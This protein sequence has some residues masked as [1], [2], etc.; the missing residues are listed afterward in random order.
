MLR[1]VG[2][3]AGQH[4]ILA[5]NFAK[6]NYKKITESAT[7]LKERRKR[8]MREA[9]K[10]ASDLKKRFKEM[11]RSKEKFRKSFEEQEK[12]MLTFKRA[13]ND[14]S[15]AR[16]EVEKL[17]LAYNS[18]TQHCETVKG[19]Y[20]SQLIK[21]NDFQRE[22]YSKLFPKVLD[23]LQELEKSRIGIM[24]DSI[25]ACV[26]K[27]KEVN[28]IINKCHDSMIQAMDDI[29]PQEDTE[30]VIER[31]KSGDVP[32]RDFNFD[33]MSSPLEMLIKEPV[34]KK[35]N[36]NLYPR[37][38]ELERMIDTIEKELAQRVKELSSF[39]TLVTTYEANP[40]FGSKDD[41]KK[42][43]QEI[44]IHRQKIHEMETE[45]ERLNRE[46]S[47]VEDRLESLKNNSNSLS[48]SPMLL[49]RYHTP[50]SS[51]SSG[52]LKS[53]SLSIGST[54]A[55]S[56]MNTS[57]DHSVPEIVYDRPN[58]EWGE[59]EEEEEFPPPPPESTT[60][61][62]PQCYA[63]YAYDGSSTDESSNIIPMGEGERFYVVEEDYAGW[64]RVR[65]IDN[66]Y[67]NDEGEGFVPSSFIQLL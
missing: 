65:R 21:T 15:V 17:R 25:K 6:E 32:P 40:K 43:Q 26:Y 27:E 59:E 62:L 54:Q 56:T 24:R 41:L 7:R 13:D 30:I 63:L 61:L 52:S 38:K 9:D 3:L 37:K 51:H 67:Y 57:P 18:R 33:D 23:D 16:N 55:S 5:E 45:L 49:Q 36:L 14:G 31:Y 50:R 20:A 60:Q 22:Y 53:S 19:Q 1:E 4:E 28:S 29:N 48:Q 12:S 58:D 35:P 46:H 10:L 39:Q 34:D 2:F 42:L 64:T 11:D 47:S 66:Q 8:S 44:S